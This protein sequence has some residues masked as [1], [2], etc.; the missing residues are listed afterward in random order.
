MSAI[1]ERILHENEQSAEQRRARWAVVGLSVLGSALVIA[2][3]F[4]PYWKFNLVAPQ[5]PMGLKLHISLSGITGDVREID[6]LNHYIGMMPMATAAE[7][8]RTAAPYLVSVAAI[9]VVLALVA[10]GKRVGWLGLVPGFA[11]PVGFVLDTLYWM[12]RFGHEL[13]PDQPINFPTFMPVLLGHGSIGQFHTTAWPDWGFYVAV[14]GAVCVAV[15]LRIR[16]HVCD[17]C[18]KASTCGAACPQLMV[19]GKRA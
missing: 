12:Y 16:R 11:L 3:Y 4:L 8:E 9:G 18:P 1:S 2:S 19:L 10:A 5:Y 7:L 6:I 14:A 17:T 13:D 15:A